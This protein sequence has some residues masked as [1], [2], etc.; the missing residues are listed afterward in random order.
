MLKLN[1]LLVVPNGNCHPRSSHGVSSHPGI[2]ARP[3]ATIGSMYP[4]NRPV[5]PNVSP[6]GSCPDL[7][8]Q[9]KF[10]PGIN[11]IALNCR[12]T[13]SPSK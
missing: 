10:A 1:D 13:T 6:G 5:G 2:P 12:F 8:D 7:T 11:S 4:Y 9:V 3:E